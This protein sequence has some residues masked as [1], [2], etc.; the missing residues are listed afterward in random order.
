M[1]KLAERAQCCASLLIEPDTGRTQ[2]Q[3]AQLGHFSDGGRQFSQGG[4]GHCQTFKAG[5]ASE[6]CVGRVRP[7]DV[8]Q[9][10]RPD[11]AEISIQ[12]W[13]GSIPRR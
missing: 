8:V 3:S 9:I 2:I 10:Q 6:E 7:G 1:F 13:K 12:R 11:M 4:A 5:K